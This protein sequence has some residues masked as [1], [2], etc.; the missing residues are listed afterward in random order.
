M[1]SETLE[2]KAHG[3]SGRD[4]LGLGM[5]PGRAQHRTQ[6]RVWM[7]PPGD[8]NRLLGLS[9]FFSRVFES[10]ALLSFLW[11][12][13]PRRILQ[14]NPRQNSPNVYYKIRAHAKGV[15]LVIRRVSAF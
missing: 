7:A 8:S 4:H 15:V 10:P 5:G 1:G 2:N 3:E 12:K 13:V 14:E 9:E 11:G 6:A